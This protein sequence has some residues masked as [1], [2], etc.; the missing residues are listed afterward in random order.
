MDDDLPFA[1]Y[2]VR[3]GRVYQYVR[4]IPLDLADAIPYS[5]IQRSLRTPDRATAFHAGAHVHAE[6]E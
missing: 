6:V 4:R 2:V 5:R 1:C 3:R